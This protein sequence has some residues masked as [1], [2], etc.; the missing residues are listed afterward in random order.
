[1]AINKTTDATKDKIR[2]KSAQFLPD[3][4][5]AR[6]MKAD[7]IRKAFYMPVTDTADSILYEMDRIVDEANTELGAMDKALENEKSAREKAD[8]ALQGEIDANA[9][10]IDDLQNELGDFKTKTENNLNG[11]VN[12]E[13]FNARMTP[14]EN[15]SKEHTSQI[16]ALQ[17]VTTGNSRSYVVPD[18]ITLADILTMGR[19]DI[20]T[21]TYYTQNLITGDN[22]LIIEKNV[23][24]F[25][26]EATRDTSREA[27]VYTHIVT[28]E[29]GN[30]I[31]TDYELRVFSYPDGGEE[32]VQVGLLHILESDYTVIEGYSKSASRSATEAAESASAASDSAESAEASAGEAATYKTSAAESAAA[33]EESASRAE[34]AVG[35]GPTTN[36]VSGETVNIKNATNVNVSVS[37][38]NVSLIENR[39][40]STSK[41]GLTAT[42]NADKSVTINGTATAE[43]DFPMQDDYSEPFAFLENVTYYL[44]GCPVGGGASTY[45]LK[46]DWKNE[47]EQ[48]AAKTDVGSGAYWFCETS[49][50]PS[51]FAFRIRVAANAVLDNVTFY[52][53]FSRYEDA[54]YTP[55]GEEVS[56]DG[57]TIT[58]TNNQTG[59]G[60]SVTVNPDG[61]TDDI[62]L[63]DDM[64][65]SVKEYLIMTATY[66]TAG[67]AKDINAIKEMVNDHERR[68][69]ALE[70]DGVASYFKEEVET[71]VD[72]IIEKT[73]GCA[74]VLNVLTDTHE[75]LSDSE[76]VRI[77]NETYANVKAVND[78]VWCDALIH[79]GDSCESSRSL[80]PDWKTVNAHLH[81]TRKRLSA[82]N[83]HSVMLVGNHDGISSLYPD[84]HKTFNAMYAYTR[85]YVKRNGASPYGYMDFEDRRIRCIF[86]ATSMYL[87][88][89]GRGTTSLQWAQVQWLADV[90]NATEDGWHVLAFAHYSPYDEAYQPSKNYVSSKQ[91]GA[92]IGLLD[93][94][95]KHTAYQFSYETDISLHVDFTEKPNARTV[96][97]FTGHGHYDRVVKDNSYVSAYALSYPIV[98]TACARLEQETEIPDDNAD[99]VV[100]AD[101]VTPART[102]KTVTQDLWDTLV[103][104]PDENKIYMLRFG[105]GEDREIGL[106]SV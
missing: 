40:K 46:L 12:N 66:T 39:L 64:S 33:A 76:S 14:L 74:L 53:M 99:G 20:G 80:Y 26:F 75:N 70:N 92:V 38:K 91:Y 42:V 82:C 58:V 18:F 28:D 88:Y 86:L 73:E 36:T 79:L 60:V 67:I 81:S 93:A 77:C 27:D 25:W 68:I 43:T 15:T 106:S 61:T 32:S 105:A 71:T 19:W 29:E 103:Y 11:K 47:N 10:N 102:T 72:T 48:W 41:N 1:M 97:L 49:Y 44:T 9:T 96:G 13:D 84:E 62:P 65:L 16:T 98:M 23:P 101:V 24:D 51:A 3:N 52:P 45:M 31:A 69:T 5:S 30:E 6:G 50:T 59:E 22:L 37:G 4:P 100:D 78:R 63:F 21:D 95:N 85:D 35:I 87:D 83:A 17:T 57:E 8:Y 94:F 54:P 2:R 7:D 56:V 104:R 89:S 55:Y 34:E 90:L